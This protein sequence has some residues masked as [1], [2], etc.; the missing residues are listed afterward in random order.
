[1]TI[2]WYKKWKFK[3]TFRDFREANVSI[4]SVYS[5]SVLW[6][7]RGDHPSRS[8]VNPTLSRVQFNVFRTE[9]LVQTSQSVQNIAVSEKRL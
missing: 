6:S 8:S 4:K 2:I 3:P 7:P 1:M 5:N 9:M